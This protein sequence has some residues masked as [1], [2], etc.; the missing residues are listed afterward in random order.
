MS[1]STGRNSGNGV[2]RLR[3]VIDTNVVLSGITHR[4]IPNRILQAGTDRWF[5]WIY[6]S[7]IL[8]EYLRI[9]RRF[10]YAEEMVRTIAVL[11]SAGYPVQV[12]SFLP[13]TFQEITDV[14]DRTIF[15]AARVGNAVFVTGNHRHFPWKSYSGVQIL[16]PRD[17][18]DML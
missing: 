6:S 16:S 14:Q 12:P 3:A 17:F 4:G 8:D 10:G 1:T 13:E 11:H 15:A 9:G 18:Y 5:A 7:E 2:P